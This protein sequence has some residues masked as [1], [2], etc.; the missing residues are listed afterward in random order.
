MHRLR[1]IVAIVFT[2]TSCAAYAMPAASVAS[3]HPTDGADLVLVNGGWNAGLRLGMA[4]QV[5]RQGLRI[6]ELLLVDVQSDAAV[7]LIVQLAPGQA[8]RDGDNVSVKIS[9]KPVS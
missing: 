4:C 8:M 6:A 5:G 2:V 7:G 3:I 1:Q 9:Q